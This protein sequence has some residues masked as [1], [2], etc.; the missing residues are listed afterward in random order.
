L[1]ASFLIYKLSSIRDVFGIKPEIACVL[2]GSL[3]A[4][5]ETASSS[6]AVCFTRKTPAASVTHQHWSI[7]AIF[8]FVNYMPP[9]CVSTEPNVPNPSLLDTRVFVV[10][11]SSARKCLALVL[12]GW[13]WRPFNPQEAPFAH[14]TKTA[15]P[16]SSAVFQCVL[17]EL[18]A[19]DALPTSRAVHLS[20]DM[21]I[22]AAM[23]NVLYWR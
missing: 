16:S 7:E 4:A 2:I 19:M 12:S 8:T 18:I 6:H 17:L 5:G 3:S 22:F 11:F 9:R 20:S 14:H 21:I 23:L 10:R 1:P 15:F 13:R